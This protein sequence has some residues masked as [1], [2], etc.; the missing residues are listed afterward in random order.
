MLSFSLK[1]YWLNLYFHD[2]KMRTATKADKEIVVSI[3]SCQFALVAGTTWMMR[4]HCSTGHLK[5][6]SGL[7]FEKTFKRKGV[8]I[9]NNNQ[10][11]ALCYRY[12][13]KIF[14]IEEI[15]LTIYFLLVKVKLS[16]LWQ[17]IKLELYKKKQRPK[18]G[19]YLYFWFFAVLKGGKDAG[20]ELKNEIFEMAKKKHLPIYAETSL[21]RN[22]C[23][24]E[25]YGFQTY[26]FWENKKEHLQYWFMKY[27]PT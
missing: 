12:N 14:S 5:F 8:F 19:N 3:L 15:L 2:V 18:S 27:N 10:G 24:Y 16:K 13:L 20:F 17:F 25:R 11:I 9:S 6:L 21:R 23:I 7:A 26:H 22:K 4:K 1:R